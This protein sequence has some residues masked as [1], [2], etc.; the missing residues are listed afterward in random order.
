V[1]VLRRYALVYREF[2]STSV[3]EATSYRLHFVLLVAMDLFFYGS[4]LWSVGF[5]F[6]HVDAIGP[7][8]R[9]QVLLFMS[10]MLAVDHLH[11]T[12]VSEN[13]WIF[14]FELKAGKLDFVLIRPLGALF[15]VFFRHV[16]V[17]S[18]CNIVVPWAC[19][20]H[21]GRQAGLSP[22]AWAL[23]PPL[24]LLALTLLVSLEILL[25]MSMFWLVESMGINFLR[26][27]LQQVAR[28]PDVAY[29][30]AAQRLFT[31][32]FPVLLVGSAPV[33]FL[34]DPMDH[35]HLLG[36]VAAILASWIAIAALWRVGL[37]AYES[38]SS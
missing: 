36:M 31:F 19:I 29:R 21:F 5:I 38:A 8:G 20:V 33:R 12:F 26:M 15:S 35:G 28:W 3:T 17:A 24:V 2:L 22:L 27:Q 30:H 18:L 34:L 32:V 25:S 14:S 37:R 6:D 13:F 7:W 16:R 1:T 4:T 10:F 9:S 11:M 23:L